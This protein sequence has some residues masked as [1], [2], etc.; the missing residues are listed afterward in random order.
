MSRHGSSCFVAKFNIAH[1]VPDLG[2]RAV[3]HGLHGYREVVETLRWGLADLGHDATITE[4]SF[5][6]DRVN[7]VIG[8]QVLADA[9]LRRLPVETIIYN[10]EQIA[11]FSTDQ[12]KPEIRTVGERFQIWEYSQA[13]IATWNAVGT[14]HTVRHVPVGWAPILA[15]INSDAPQDIDVLFYGLPG[16]LRLEIFYDLCRLGIKCVF[17]CGL[18]GA[19]RDDLI[20]RSKLVL[21]INL[22]QSRIFEI[23][24]VSYLLANAK[25]VV[26]DIQADTFVEPGI[27]GAVVFCEPSQVVAEC[28]ALLENDETRHELETRGRAIFEKRH[29]SPILSRALGA[30]GAH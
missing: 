3:T 22:Y 21:N 30:P 23:V 8:A 17:V 6:G 1:I 19:A 4:N 26:A 11:K 13:N 9:D 28:K 25:A 12:L 29:I 18:Y 16:Q 20:A 5:A 7:I 14:R 2:A 24:R 27:E 10:F 15:R